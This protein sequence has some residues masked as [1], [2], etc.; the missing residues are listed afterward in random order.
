MIKE[1]KQ[2]FEING[3]GSA[4]QIMSERILSKQMRELKIRMD[5]REKP[6][7]GDCI[8]NAMNPVI[9]H[10][11]ITAITGENTPPSSRR[12][13]MLIHCYVEKRIEPDE[14]HYDFLRKTR[15]P[16]KK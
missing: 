3:P 7:V 13:T 8:I 14:A 4:L 10:M 15:Q 5:L 12:K 16:D 9:Y 2:V 11:Q 1:T 6:K